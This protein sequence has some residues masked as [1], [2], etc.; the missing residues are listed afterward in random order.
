MAP[1][2][3]DTLPQES[4]WKDLTVLIQPSKGLFHLD[5]NAIWYYR[6]LLYFLIWRDVKVRYKQTVIGAG[7]AILQPLMT[8]V[9][10]SVVFGS[11]AKIPSDGLPY[12]IFT[13][14]ALLPWNF[15][16]QAIG[17]SGIS[18]VGSA[19]L[20]SK[21]YF[22]RLIIPLS[23][24]VAPLV[25]LAFAFVILLGMMAWF[26][27]A[28]TW[29]VLALPLFLLLALGTALAAGLWL[30]AL[31]V[32]YRDIGY[33]IPFLIQI[34]MYASPVAYPVSIV[35]ERWRLLY[36]LNP[37]AGVIEGFRWAL[38]GTGTPNIGVMVVSA[39]VVMMLMSSGLVY[40]RIAERTFADVV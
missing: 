19:N 38:L 31:N 2:M 6:E 36:S 33:T 7:W 17:R 10:F 21:I 15:F 3:I 18:L 1:M 25:D 8:M 39:V 29:G 20:I 12:P 26:G 11:F 35:P 32:R 13:F 27:V 28:P 40:F 5:L 34:W 4:E 16:A 22:P 14:A 37:M 30:S 9:I 23:A 24:A